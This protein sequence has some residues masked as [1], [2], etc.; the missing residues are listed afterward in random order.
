MQ[1]SKR[2]TASFI[3]GVLGW[4]VST[5]SLCQ[6]VDFNRYSVPEWQGSHA[7]PNFSGRSKEFYTFRTVIRDGFRRGP[8]VAGHYSLIRIGC[9]MECVTYL[10]GD[11]KDGSIISLP[12]GGEYYP[13][14]TLTTAPD[15]RLVVAKWGDPLKNECTVRSY[16]LVGT[17]F[18]QVGQDRK[19]R[20]G[21]EN[22]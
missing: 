9:G 14:L 8:I 18:S 17:R 6:S 22:F 11:V 3:L 4:M 7:A 21:C 2:L 13:S 5:P 12:I 10:F 20:R 16:V 1:F 19:L 15:S